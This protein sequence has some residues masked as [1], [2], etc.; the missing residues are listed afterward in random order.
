MSVTGLGTTRKRF[1]LPILAI[2]SAVLILAAFA[3]SMVEL[4][5]FSQSKE[6]LQVDITV[7]G[8]PVSGLKLG[9]AVSAWQRVYEQPVELLYQESPILL[10]P[11]EIDFRTND[12]RMRADVQARLT[13]TDNYWLD[14]WNYLWR[15]PTNPITISLVADY[16]QSRLRSYLEDIATRYE[17]PAGSASFVVD[18]MTFG[19]GATGLRL[20]VDASIQAIDAALRRPTDRK[21][22]LVMRSEGGRVATMQTLKEAIL[23]YLTGKGVL[24]DGQ[25]TIA[26][27]MLIDLQTG[28][29][30]SINPDVAYTASSTIKIPILLN[31][32]RKW[33]F[34][35]K[36]EEKWLLAASILC[37]SNSASNFLM[38]IA[39]VG[40]NESAR[41]A[42]G[43]GQVTTTAQTLGA[44]NTFISAPLYVA[45]SKYQFSI[46][47]PKTTPNPQLN[48]RPDPYSQTTAEDMAAMLHDLY[49]CA[50][51]G[52]GL[53]AVFPN[54]YTQ[55]E[56]KQMIELLSGNIIGR[57][58]EL[59]VPAGTR[60]AHKNG[61]ARATVEG[62]NGYTTG[63]AAI[64]YTRGGAYILTVYIWEQI[65]PG[66]EVG[67]IYPWEAIEGVSRIVYNY[68]NADNPMLVSRVPENAYTAV[69][70]IM[71]NVAHLE[72]IDLNNIN[73]GRFDA[74]G[75][76]V[77][78]ACFNYPAC[79]I[80]PPTKLGNP[81][82]SPATPNVISGTR[83]ANTSSA[84]GTPAPTS[85]SNGS[86]PT[87][88]P[89]PK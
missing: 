58:I 49:D 34:A 42:N 57:L 30:L 69:E 65:K 85:R 38:Q 70:C 79:E 10:N 86:A 72:R 13:G 46:Q 18:T 36:D 43:L 45:D 54:G 12:E 23:T 84:T 15:R 19:S 55:N 37:S 78:D 60:V 21:V 67:S 66:Q 53:M 33:D 11:A 4:T 73:N 40:E 5:R 16:P 87:L 74:N 2:M 26:S 47:R 27:V 81:D 29:E 28:Q 52:S 35:P 48:A 41:L 32:F 88:L 77:P 6:F 44:K 20:D 68:F 14:F 51:Y 9:D 82:A 75:H 71:P 22:K 24:I 25:N 7:A 63:D 89:P 80:I 3:M 61:W 17:Q 76:I 62:I 64:I 8:V 83:E 56:C 50:E 59:G 1:H 39:G 31:F